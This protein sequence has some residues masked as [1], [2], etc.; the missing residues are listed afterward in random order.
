MTLFDGWLHETQKLQEETYHLDLDHFASTPSSNVDKIVNLIDYISINVTAAIHE[1]VE[2]QSETS[3]KPWQMDAPYAHRDQIR[4]EAVDV[5]HFVANILMAIG[6][7]DEELNE[8]YLAKMQINRDRQNRASGYLIK[9]EG[10]KCRTCH[11]ALDDVKPS[12]EDPT[13]C[14]ACRFVEMAHA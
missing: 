6:V 3:W 12:F 14:M 13:L 2:L 11:R 10:V 8:A 4:G 5:L 7:T 9:A 1:L